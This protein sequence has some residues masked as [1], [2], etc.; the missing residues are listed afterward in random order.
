MPDETINSYANIITT[1][2]KADVKDVAWRYLEKLAVNKRIWKVAIV[3]RL[4]DSELL[5]TTPTVFF[6][7]A[8]SILKWM[9]RNSESDLRGRHDPTWNIVRE[10]YLPKFKEIIGSTNDAWSSYHR[11]E[12]RQILKSIVS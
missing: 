5:A 12:V 3:W 4:F 8:S 10:H 11:V 7:Y 6:F 1:S 9:L 2:S